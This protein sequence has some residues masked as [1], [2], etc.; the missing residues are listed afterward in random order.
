MKV[1]SMNDCDW[2]AGETLESCMAEY[3]AN[4]S[5]NYEWP[6]DEIFE[7]PHE[8]PDEKMDAMKFH[9][10]DGET[11]TFRE[12]LPRLIERGVSFPT[13]FASTEY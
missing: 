2:M 12:E 6:D 9:A 8:V 5:G 13:F 3:R 11:L 4:F 10:D 7:D 1:F